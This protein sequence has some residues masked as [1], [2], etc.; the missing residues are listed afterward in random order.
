LNDD[1]P[2]AERQRGRIT[3]ISLAL[4]PVFPIGAAARRTQVSAMRA[5]QPW[6]CTT[7]YG[8]A[9]T[10]AHAF[11]VE[12][13][14]DDKVDVFVQVSGTNVILDVVGCVL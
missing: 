3:S 4:V 10:V 5:R 6:T 7:N 13:R 11:N 8:L 1:T 12:L 14:S 2:H 9:Q